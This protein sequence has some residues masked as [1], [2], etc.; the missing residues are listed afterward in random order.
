MCITQLD[1]TYHFIQ[2]CIDS[3][4]LRQSNSVEKLD[5]T[6]DDEK[7]IKSNGSVVTQEENFTCNNCGTSFQ[8]KK[9]LSQHIF[10]LHSKNK[11]DGESNNVE[12]SCYNTPCDT[13]QK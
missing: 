4:Q 12:Q 6:D 1:I 8:Q 3:E 2:C 9:Y 7:S 10:E 5:R 11:Y 13:L